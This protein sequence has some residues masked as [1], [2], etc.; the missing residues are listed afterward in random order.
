MFVLVNL[1]RH[2]DV[3]PEMALRDTNTKFRTRFAHIEDRLNQANKTL[4]NA[5]LEEMEAYWQQAKTV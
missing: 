3:N 1:G 2:V 5:S 4:E